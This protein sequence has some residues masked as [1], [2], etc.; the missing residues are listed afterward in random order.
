MHDASE[1]EPTP[2]SGELAQQ[3]STKHGWAFWVIFAVMCSSAFASAL[4]TLI[5]TTALPQVT[6]SIGGQAQ[7]VWIANCFVFSST[8]VQPLYGQ[9]SNIFGR[10]MPMLIALGLFAFGSG[11]AGGAR[12]VAML[13]AGRTVSGLGSA[14]LFLLSDLI[15]CDLVPL[16]ERAKYMGIILST[17]AIGT[18]IGPI[19]GGAL[20]QASWRWVFYINLTIAIPS[21]ILM[22]FFLRLKHKS[23]PTWKAALKR[24]DWIGNAI[25]IPSILAILIGLVT[26]GTTHPWSSWRIILPMVLGG[27]GWIIFHVYESS[28]YCLEPSVPPHLFTNRTSAGGFF[29]GFN[30]GMLL[31]WVAYFMPFYFQSVLTKSPVLSG[32]YVLPFNLFMIPSAM[33]AGGLLSKTGQ[34]KPLHWFGFA[35]LAIACGLFSI[36]DSHSHRVAWVFFQ[37]IAAIGLGFV[38]TSVLPA[39]QAGLSEADVATATGAFSFLRGF[40]FI[41]GVTLPSI[42]FNNQF[43]K[44]LNTISDVDLRNILANGKAY[45]YATSGY[46]TSLSGTL[47]E[48]VVTA[49]SNSLHTVWQVALAFSLLGFLVVFVE[50]HIKLRTDLETEFGLDDGRKK[51]DG[52]GLKKVEE[53]GAVE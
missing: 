40:G 41:W 9:V 26:G 19:V 50:K 24:V 14:G 48:E 52:G 6:D 45:G 7:Y 27:V 49:Y 2:T 16:R 28:R 36:L 1:K 17:A 47:R 10:R 18:T 42:I 53:D 32:V 21:L 13:I 31:N 15:I 3:E 29:L 34:Y 4:D 43:D 46:I 39:I 22:I 11:I 35:M 30:S 12:N 44:H 5:I 25:F 8:V 51:G 20:A 38:M 37:I 23:E 33:V